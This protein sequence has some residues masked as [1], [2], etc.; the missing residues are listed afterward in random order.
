VYLAGYHAVYGP[1]YRVAVNTSGYMASP[2]AS[3]A[4]NFNSSKS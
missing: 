3:P 4:P 2:Q 1:K